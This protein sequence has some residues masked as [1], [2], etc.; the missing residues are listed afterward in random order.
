LREKAEERRAIT[1]EFR[2][3]IAALGGN[4]DVGG[5]VSAALHRRFMDLRALFQNDTKA[6]VAEVERGEGYLQERFETYMADQRLSVTTRDLI[7]STYA[8]VRFDHARWDALKQAQ[9]SI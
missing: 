6:A 3:R 8:R 4:A 2:N 1:T 5:S 9:G 7:R